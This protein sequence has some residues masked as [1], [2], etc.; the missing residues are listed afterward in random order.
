[1]RVRADGQNRSFD[2]STHWIFRPD[3]YGCCGCILRKRKGLYSDFYHALRPRRLLY[4]R[5]GLRTA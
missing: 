3:D 2:R 1:V 4:F 5:I